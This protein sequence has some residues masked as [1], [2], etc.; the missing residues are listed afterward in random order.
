LFLPRSVLGVDGFLAEC[1]AFPFGKHDDQ[2]D[3][4]SQFLNYRQ[5]KEYNVFEFD[6]GHSEPPGSPDAEMLLWALRR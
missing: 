2:V 3:A 4:L 6:F 1:L 5:N